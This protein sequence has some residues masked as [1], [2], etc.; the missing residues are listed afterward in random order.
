MKQ[1]VVILLLL[2]PVVGDLWF[3]ATCTG[4]TSAPVDFAHVVRPILSANCFACH[5]R[6]E[7]G[8]KADLRLDE[9]APAIEYG[10]I[11]P[12]DVATSLLI[13]RITA[14]DLELRMPPAGTGHRLTET[15]I[16]LLKRWI[17]QGAKYAEH[18]S[19]VAP[20]RSSIPSVITAEWPRNSID[21]F[22]LR[23]L[24]ESGLKPSPQADPFTLVKRVYLDLIGLPPTPEVAD[25][26]AES[27]SEKAYEQLVDELLASPKYGEHWARVW[28]DLARYADT[29]GYEKDLPRDMW[30]FRDWM[31]RA[32]NADMPY[33][34]FTIEQL[35]GDLLPSPSRE[36]LI[37]SAF[38]RNTMSNDEGG[39]DDEEFRVAAVKDRVDTTM[40]VWMGLTAGCAKCHSHKYDPISHE[41]Y[42]QL[43][44][45]F[46][47]TADRDAFDEAPVLSFASDEQ[48]K[49]LDDLQRK[50]ASLER[51]TLP[52]ESQTRSGAAE[53]DPTLT[54]TDIPIPLVA[55]KR[56]EQLTDLKQQVQILE[57]EITNLPVMREL[58]EDQRRR[59]H[60]HLRGN[61]LDLGEAVSPGVPEAFGSL[62]GE[63]RPDRLALAKWLIS[64]ENSLSARVA[65]NR[66]WARFF[67]IGIV[68]TEGDFGSQGAQ[69]SHPQLLDWLAVE[70]RDTYQWSLKRLC[71]AI[72]LSATYRQ[73]STIE[74]AK[75]QVDPRNRLLSRGPRFRLPAETVRDQAL[76]ASGLLS[77]KMYG[78]PSMPPQPLG[79]WKTIYNARNWVTSDGEDRYR[80]AL[81]TYWKR[82]SPYPAMLIFDAES[83]DV[84]TVRRIATNTPLQ[85]LVLMND[86]VYLESAAALARRMIDEGGSAAE[87]RLARGFRHLVTR[88]PNRD[89]L[90]RLEELRL[91]ADRKFRDN[92]QAAADF[93]KSCNVSSEL[94]SPLHLEEYASYV[95]VASVLL[96]L[97]EAITRN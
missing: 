26:F 70:L 25:R 95:V 6:D 7:E 91:A 69:P 32:L 46:N 2:A 49:K 5:G 24:E 34:Q 74:P 10:A 43:F 88:A 59:T 66:I 56:A 54:K 1:R 73:A 21:F 39:T 19:F 64:P 57:D 89:E 41:E 72:V 40:Q 53:A 90:S 76:A 8:R 9:R 75:M 17:L 94:T 29:K 82:T 13:E 60:I 33:D 78:A 63:A 58:P 97:D 31:I 18:W 83:R 44:A 77:P 38:H 92:P 12:G 28:L 85:A 16:E 35:A 14:D 11:V 79:V 42:Y 23:R 68:E 51:E 30:P 47:Q 65:A 22:T 61:F 50:I 81:Y 27:P 87:G 45:I 36:Q 96:N 86:Q 4:D 15:E 71:R 84:C 37:A 52:A 55:S 20:T 3:A 67:G 62:D 93:L 80:R 48:S